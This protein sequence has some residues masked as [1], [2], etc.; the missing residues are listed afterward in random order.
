MKLFIDCEW[1]SYKGELM[2]MALVPEHGD[3]WYEVLKINDNPHE[4]VQANVVPKLGKLPIGRSV[5]Q[6]SLQQY[7]MRFE[8]VHI[9]ADWPEDIERFCELLIVEAGVRINTPPLLCEITRIDSVSE[10]P[11]NALA[12]AIGLKKQY[13]SQSNN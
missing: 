13:L 8:F 4:W 5:A 11:H 1:N 9:V 7:L 6:K 3:P 12:D 10:N 2:S